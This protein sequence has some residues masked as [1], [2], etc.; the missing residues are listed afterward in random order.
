MTLTTTSNKAVVVDK[1]YHWIPITDD[2][3]P[4]PGSKVQLINREAGVA[5][6]GHWRPGS[7]WTHYAG[8]PTFHPDDKTGT[9]YA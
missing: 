2:N 3:H 8:L 6:Y 4:M 5:M 1:D 9:K 7:E